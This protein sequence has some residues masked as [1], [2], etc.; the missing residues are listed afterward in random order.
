[1]AVSLPGSAR[2]GTPRPVADAQSDS[3]TLITGDR[4][5]LALDG[6][7]RIA[8][9]EGRASMPFRISRTKDGLRV[10]PGD[11][12]ALIAAGRL[13]G[14]L[15]DVTGLLAQGYDDAR[16]A[17]LPLIVQYQEGAARTAIAS[18]TTIRPLSS[19][20]GA[21]VSVAKK[22]APEWWRTAVRGHALHAGLAKVWLNGHRQLS[23][24]RS[25]A[26]IGA[27]AAWQA[28][29]TGRQVRVAVIDSGIDA[30]HPDLSGKVDAAVNFTT[31]PAG[32]QIGHGTHVASTVA[33]TGAASGGR[34]R[35][36]APD[37]RLLDAKVCQQEGCPEDAILAGLE[38]ASVT[39]KA[40]VANISLGGQDTPGIDPIE[41]AVNTLSAQ[42]GTLF[43]VAAGNTGP[44][45]ATVESPGSAEA[46]LTVGAVSREDE[47]AE[48]SSRGP[49]VG[50]AGLKPDLTAPGVGIVAARAS[51]TEMGEVVDDWYVAASGTSMATP[52]VAGSAALLVQQHP[53]WSSEQLKTALMASARTTRG[54]GVLDQGAGRVDV[55]AAI[56]QSVTAAPASVSLGVKR[57]PHQ[58][59]ENLSKTVTYRNTGS[60]DVALDLALTASGPGGE[61]APNQLFTVERTQVSVP[62]GGTATVTVT[63]HTGSAVVPTGRYLG[64]LVATG[65]GETV[66]TPVAVEKESEHYD[67]ELTHIG[68][69]GGA[70]GSY[71]TWLDRLG[72]CGDDPSCGGVVFGQE[73]KSKLR[74]PPG[75]YTLGDFTTTTGTTDMNMQMQFVLEVTG[76]KTL[77]LDARRAKPV[78][79]GVPRAS[80]RL[81]AWDI[82]ASRDMDRPGEVLFY[83]ASGDKTTPA[84]TADLGGEPAEQ[85]DVVSF[86][87]AR[88]AEPGPAGDFFAS[89]YEYG[90]AEAVH[91]RLFT[92]L[93]LQPRQQDFATVDSRFVAYADGREFKTGHYAQPTT[94]RPELVAFPG[95]FDVLY[96]PL[97]FRRTEYLLAKNLTWTTGVTT[98]Y[99]GSGGADF[100]LHEGQPSG[101]Q[102]G[103]SYQRVWNQAV[104]GP[105]LGERRIGGSIAGNGAVR[106][107]DVFTAAIDQ[108]VDAVPG[109]I[110]MGAKGMPGSVRLF[111][112]GALITES[113][114]AG[115]LRTTL[116]A[117]PATYRLEMATTMPDVWTSTEV[118]TA[119]T[120]RSGHVDG[121]EE[122]ALPLL[123]VRYTPELDDR[124]HA[125]PG[126]GFRI[127]LQIYRQP[128][129]P[130][131]PVIADLAVEVSHDDGHSWRP[132]SVT[133]DGLR[134]VA[135][136]DNPAGAAVSLRTKARDTDGNKLLQTVTR[137]YLVNK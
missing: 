7:P 44:F 17:D 55:A 11:A 136:V 12:A 56:T 102:A 10:V 106:R 45:E 74:L 16:R 37:A 84:F 67:V 62:A 69:D 110:G 75:R 129:A 6:T 24:D 99:R 42:Y 132:A 115:P 14:R 122:V 114:Q 52:H 72:D 53:E 43:V 128:G 87:H 80:A 86:V 2:A 124:N 40:H 19:I 36:I 31:D 105:Q 101:Y 98:G 73:S 21:A 1:M 27:P 29:L 123:G 4:V 81:K 109:H 104:F 49:R 121:T 20:E 88:F 108:F 13:D 71:V 130:G 77:M 32:D 91:G 76:D 39:Q 51:G 133:R 131:A 33:G 23:L 65:G 85:A 94:G 83:T 9:G 100:H 60:A 125:R 120:F 8:R 25:A 70:P 46:A 47:V 89:P 82:V 57:W 97:P 22:N 28:G 61:P 30:M 93:K 50:D 15:F 126:S 18:A 66:T 135:T 103:R 118:N 63:A 5:E 68:R 95:G 112:D 134:W 34:Y 117:R 116:P 64:R 35:G 111:Q 113:P 26:Q 79:L 127:P 96:G 92:G 59:G 137:A 90:V 38:W 78:E 54:A 119:W 48:F 107:G 3:V 58:P 41:Q